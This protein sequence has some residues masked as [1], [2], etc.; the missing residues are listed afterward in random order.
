MQMSY[1]GKVL[2]GQRLAASPLCRTPIRRGTVSTQASS[3]VDRCAKYTSM[4]FVSAAS[5]FK[6]VSLVELL[7]RDF[8]VAKNGADFQQAFTRLVA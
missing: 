7:H 4:N 6:Q 5:R 8:F 1:A 2:G 3:R